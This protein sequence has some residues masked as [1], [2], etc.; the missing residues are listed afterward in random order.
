[1]TLGADM[2]Q[3]MVPLN[4][5]REWSAPRPL[6]PQHIL[7]TQTLIPMSKSQGDGSVDKSGFCISMRT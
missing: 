5:S 3:S 2:T 4:F 1:M 6:S 7:D